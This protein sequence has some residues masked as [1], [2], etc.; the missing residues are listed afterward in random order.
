MAS[1]TVSNSKEV[2]LNVPLDDG[3][4]DE[5]YHYLFKPII[6]KVTEIFKPGAVVLL[7]GADSSSGDRLGCFNLSI[8]TG[9]ALGAQVEDKMPH[10]EYYEYFGPDYI[11]HVCP[12]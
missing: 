7:C 9:V 11:L 8:K 3:I 10:H 4:D 6:G 12:E 5:S 2:L 1:S